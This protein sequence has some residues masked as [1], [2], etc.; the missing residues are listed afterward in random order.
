M[1]V[2]VFPLMKLMQLL[3]KGYPEK[4]PEKQSVP[5]F[6]GFSVLTRPFASYPAVRT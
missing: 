2:F 5:L 1:S 6:F 3:L 4:A